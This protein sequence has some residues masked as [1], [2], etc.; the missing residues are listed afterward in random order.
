MGGVQNVQICAGVGVILTVYFW[1]PNLSIRSVSMD[2]SPDR[3]AII[4]I[5]Y[6]VNIIYAHICALDVD[7]I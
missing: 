2:M 5:Y 4:K 1:I 3:Y 7:Y 6:V